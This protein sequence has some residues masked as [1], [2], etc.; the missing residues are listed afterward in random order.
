M[1]MKPEEVTFEWVSELIRRQ[2]LG[3]RCYFGYL[4]NKLDRK[5]VREPM[6][7]ADVSTAAIDQK[8]LT[9]Y[10]NAEFLAAFPEEQQA[11]VFEHEVLHLA[12]HHFERF[13]HAF[14]PTK[15]PSA[16]TPK[17]LIE[18]MFVKHAANIA[19]DCAI[20]Q[21]IPNFPGRMPKELK[22]KLEARAKARGDKKDPGAKEDKDD[23]ITLDA[24]KAMIQKPDVKPLQSSEYYYNLLME[25]KDK[26]PRQKV[27]FCDAD[28]NPLDGD[29]KPMDGQGLADKDHQWSASKNKE[30]GGDSAQVKDLLKSA[31]KFQENRERER[32]TEPGNCFSKC[33]PSDDVEATKDVWKKL[34]DKVFGDEPVAEVDKLFGRPS[35]RLGDTCFWFNKHQTKGKKVYVGVD[36]SGSV[37]DDE[38]EKFLGYVNKQIKRN[39]VTATLIC[40]DA[41][42][43]KEGVYEDVRHIP[44]DGIKMVGRGGTDLTKILDYIEAHEKPA[45]LSKTRLVLLTDGATPWR[46]SRIVT[47]VV[48]TKNHSKIDPVFNSAEL[49]K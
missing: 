19:C 23:F 32:G 8:A 17:E 35:R 26:L 11:A 42:I 28:G 48:Y 9:I 46:K 49:T 30:Q 6:E 29:G 40:C 34:V 38:L 2:I 44:K 1:S 41:E 47:S 5:I 37:G 33:I 12:M 27:C 43:R 21:M 45:A 36:T 15:E 14:L 18:W 39:G 13:S 22:E 25:N 20:N 16:M 31:K 4:L 7:T 24:F 10:V 3:P